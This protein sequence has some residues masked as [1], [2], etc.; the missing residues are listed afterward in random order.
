MF[1]KLKEE[2]TKEMDNFVIDEY[3]YRALQAMRDF[4]ENAFCG[5]PEGHGEKEE[6]ELAN[7]F[8]WLVMDY[9]D[10]LDASMQT[11]DAYIESHQC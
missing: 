2:R 7:M 11:I 10:L 3:Q 4:A 9:I 1:N 5:Y 8:A 6:Q